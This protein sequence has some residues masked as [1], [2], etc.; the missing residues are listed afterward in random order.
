MWEN[1]L[2]FAE[3][4]LGR[5]SMM[6]PR[7]HV[8]AVWN[9]A[10]RASLGSWQEFF[11]ENCLEQQLEETKNPSKLLTLGPALRGPHG[12]ENSCRPVW[13]V[14]ARQERLASSGLKGRF[15]TTKTMRTLCLEFSVIFICTVIKLWIRASYCG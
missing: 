6:C 15:H 7:R 2:S 1:T 3:P 14:P 4:S 8:Q 10:G 13:L 11:R 12:S 9:A 5:G